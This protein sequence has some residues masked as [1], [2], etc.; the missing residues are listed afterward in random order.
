MEEENQ[1]LDMDEAMNDAEME[2]MENFEDFIIGNRRPRRQTNWRYRH[3]ALSQTQY[4]YQIQLQNDFLFHFDL[5]KKLV[6]FSTFL[7][8]LLMLMRRE[9]MG[10]PTLFL[11]EFKELFL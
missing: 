2:D 8:T 3:D 6:C 1:N 10:T 9:E 7:L 11:T 5:I 4:A